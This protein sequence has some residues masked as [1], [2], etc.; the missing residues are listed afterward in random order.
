MKILI[1]YYSE[2]GNTAQVAQAMYEVVAGDHD[3]VLMPVVEVVVDRLGGF[4]LVVLG[5]AVHDSDV[6]KPLK[7]L[8]AALPMNPGFKLAGFAT[9]A[10]YVPDGSA[11]KDELYMRWAGKCRPSFEDTCQEKGIPFLGF[12]HCQGAASK[13]IEVFIHREIITLEEEWNAYL[14]EL[15]RH[16]SPEDLQ[17]AKDF[18]LQIIGKL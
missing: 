13:P 7:R 12:F 9:H 6:A 2:T 1:A 15:R 17:N 3:V 4:E 11:H 5:A 8:L 18:T 16:P 14:P 10:V